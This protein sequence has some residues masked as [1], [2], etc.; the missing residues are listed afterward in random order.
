MFTTDP[1]N[2]NYVT[3]KS[4]IESHLGQDNFTLVD[5]RP[6]KQ[7]T[8][9]QRLG[10]I[11]S[12]QSVPWVQNFKEDGTLKSV[13]E[14]IKLYQP[15]DVTAD[16]TVVTYC[17]EGLHAAPPWFVMTELLGYPDVRLYDAF[18][19]EWSNDPDTMLI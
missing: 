13:A 19:A 11:Y 6:F 14:L 1:F 3:N 16:K 9:H 12:A 15:H 18:M 5:G 2:T 10:Y 4:Y 17:N 8:E 7:Y